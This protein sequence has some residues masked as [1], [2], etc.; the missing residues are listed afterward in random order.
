MR[1]PWG[2]QAKKPADLVLLAWGRPAP[3]R[4]Q[5]KKIGSLLGRKAPALAPEVT[6]FPP[7]SATVACAPARPAE[8]IGILSKGAAQAAVCRL[9]VSRRNRWETC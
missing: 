9:A 8:A 7:S 3:A 1:A 2:P 6:N 5:V 4:C